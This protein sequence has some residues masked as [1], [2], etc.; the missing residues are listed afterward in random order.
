MW[1]GRVVVAGG[2][3]VAICCGV[4]A[5]GVGSTGPGVGLP[6]PAA[7]ADAGA[8]PGV[9]LA[10]IDEAPLAPA[11]RLA[12]EAACVAVK[13]GQQGQADTCGAGGAGDA[14]GKF[15]G[16]GVGAAVEVVMDE[17]NSATAV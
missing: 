11:G 15:G 17:W 9:G 2:E 10:A 13:H 7:R 8:V 3:T 6:R 14:Q 16:V 12:A 1:T 4:T 5:Q